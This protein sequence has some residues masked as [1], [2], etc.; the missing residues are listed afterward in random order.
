M[1]Q[2]HPDESQYVLLEWQTPEN[3][4]CAQIYSC[5]YPTLQFHKR[6]I[7]M[8]R[9]DRILLHYD[10]RL[11]KS[12]LIEANQAKTIDI[13]FYQWQREMFQEWKHLLHHP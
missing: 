4:N 8:K 11:L 1:R 6:I 2:Q 3:S 12:N 13:L 10:T 5:R 9:L 7:K